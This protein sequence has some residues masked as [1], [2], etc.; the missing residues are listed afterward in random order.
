MSDI[1]IYLQSIQPKSNDQEYKSNYNSY[2]EGLKGKFV[3][4]NISQSWKAYHQ[5]DDIITKLGEVVYL[6]F[7]HHGNIGKQQ[8][9]QKP[10]DCGTR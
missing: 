10:E 8:M 5:L 2:P 9:Y 6:L 7:I 4:K 1:F 3:R